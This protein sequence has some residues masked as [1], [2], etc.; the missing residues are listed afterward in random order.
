MK[1]KRCLV[2]ALAVV[3]MLL[4]QP[5]AAEALIVAVN[6]DVHFDFDQP[7]A[8]DFHVEGLIH[9]AEGSI[10]RVE[11]IFVF[12]PTAHWKV[13]GYS[14]YQPDPF[15]MPD[16]WIFTADFVTDEF[17]C[18]CEM[19]HF[20]IAFDVNCYNI[21]I[22]LRGHWT[23]D[24]E[25]L[26]PAKEV[27]VS[28]EVFPSEVAVT[29]FHVDDIGRIRPGM[30]TLRIH[31]NTNLVIE[32]PILELAVNQR[33]VPLPEMNADHLGA[34]GSGT[35]PDPSWEGLTWISVPIQEPMLEPGASFDVLLEDL[36]VHMETGD[37][38][39]IRG[40]QAGDGTLGKQAKSVW[41]F[42]WEQ[43]EAH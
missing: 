15:G 6:A 34:P 40:A 16:D 28:T 2:L 27:P 38:L 11:E 20:G 9:S 43:H 41:T 17:I 30:Q 39:Q 21:I 12:S 23:L 24:G 29:G 4:V 3:A 25:P 14:L 5:Q 8:N 33:Y 37:Y 10:P 42:F 26:F 19:L 1:M 32:V 7:C 36:G 22:D 13:K 35:S 31:N 18:Y